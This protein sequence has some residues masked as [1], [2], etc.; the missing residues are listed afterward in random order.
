MAKKGLFLDF[1]GTLIESMHLIKEAY[2]KLLEQHGKMGSEEEFHALA[3]PPTHV[4]LK[5]ILQQYNIPVSFE[6]FKVQYDTILE[7]LYQDITSLPY[8]LDLIKTACSCGW[9]V[10]IV[11]SNNRTLI[12]KWVKDNSLETF[13]SFIIDGETGGRGKPHPDP[14]AKALE[15]SGCNKEHSL[16]VEDSLT[17][18]TSALAAGLP[19]AFL[20]AH[21]PVAKQEELKRNYPLIKIATSLKDV[22]VKIK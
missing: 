21:L 18:V 5:N 12:E 11:T 1:D 8:A 20:A 2:D 4:Y 15:I 6:N 17:G 10:G 22:L 16:A 13:I 3:G 19:T 9:I 14:Y 7:S